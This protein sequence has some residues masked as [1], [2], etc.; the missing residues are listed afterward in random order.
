[1][2]GRRRLVQGS[3]HVVFC[4]MREDGSQPASEMFDQLAAGEWRADSDHEEGDRWPDERQA[5]DRLALL[6]IMSYFADHGT[7]LSRTHINDL[8]DGVWEFKR[9]RKRV[10]FFDTDGAGETGYRARNTRQEQCSR[11]EDPFWHI[12]DFHHQLRLGHCFAKTSTQTDKN[13]IYESIRTREED[14]SH[15]RAA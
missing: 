13:D 3:K 8:D 12:P 11:V 7:V 9:A 1:M 5:S 10:S 4:A 15:D 14:L 2:T 6:R